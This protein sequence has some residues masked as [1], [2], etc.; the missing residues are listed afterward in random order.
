VRP[1]PLRAAALVACLG[2]AIGLPEGV[3]AATFTVTPVQVFLSAR[4]RSALLT[5]RNTSGEAMRFQ[6]SVFAWDQAPT[7]E[8][9]LAP[10]RDI[11]F[12]PP[13][14]VLAPGEERIVRLGAATPAAAV[15]KTYRIFVEELPP[16]ERAAG[17]PGQVRV[18]TRVGIPIFIEPTR[19]V[20]GGAIEGAVL[21][22]GR[23]AFELHNPGTVHLVAQH[24]RVVGYGAAGEPVVDGTLEGWYVLA[25][26]RRRF[27]L[28]LPKDR[29][30]R[31]RSVAIEVR[32]SHGAL[33]ERLPAPAAACGP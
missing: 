15:E 13:L 32:T 1:R 16:R 6:L 23:L 31:V 9:Q 5:L 10:T 30:P 19:A 33:A 18:L 14:L 4:A 25:G 2:L 8:I 3:R 21:R 7:G 20:P 17:P 11:V 26:G 24:V 22:E 29:C 28:E 27:E 12:Y